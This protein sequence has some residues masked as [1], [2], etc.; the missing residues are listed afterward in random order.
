MPVMVADPLSPKS[1]F[2]A[3]GAAAGAVAA[4]AGAGAAGFAGVSAAERE[5]VEATMHVASGRKK[6][7]FMVKCA[8]LNTSRGDELE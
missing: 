2:G 7:G 1:S 5:S 4:G 6:P 3:A 8:G